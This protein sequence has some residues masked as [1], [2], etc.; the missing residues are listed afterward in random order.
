MNYSITLLP[1]GTI[2]AAGLGLL[3]LFPAASPAADASALQGVWRGARF[4]AGKGED[5]D[6]GVALELIIK[7]SHINGQRLP[8]GKPI[9]EGDLK[10]SAD[11]KCM[12]ATGS[13]GGFKGKAFP[14][15]FKIEGDTLFWCVTTSGNAED[16]PADFVATPSKKSYLI[17]VKRQKS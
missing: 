14:G 16:R 17:I 1:A 3:L 4:S 11:G 9:A 15:I 10:L 7:G 5:P 2:L 12:D 6:K 13:T 8:E